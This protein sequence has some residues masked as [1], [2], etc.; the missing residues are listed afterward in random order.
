MQNEDAG[1]SS[2][3]PR[4]WPGDEMVQISMA[5]QL[6]SFVDT[7]TRIK[8]SENQSSQKAPTMDEQRW[9]E[10]LMVLLVRLKV[11][12]R[13]STVQETFPARILIL[14]RNILQKALPPSTIDFARLV[15]EKTIVER[16]VGLQ[17]EIDRIFSLMELPDSGD[18]EY[19]SS[20]I[21][22]LQFVYIQHAFE[23]AKAWP[24]ASCSF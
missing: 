18:V 23:F 1:H 14:L 20:F 15:T 12:R 24:G 8:K 6:T 9:R 7:L 13:S 22:R 4:P 5:E 21:A 3:P 2:M 11:K 10:L 16:A 19:P 17:L